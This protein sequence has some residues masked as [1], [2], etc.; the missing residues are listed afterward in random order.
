MTLYTSCHPFL[1]IMTKLVSTQQVQF[2]DS[3]STFQCTTCPLGKSSRLPF[4]FSSHTTPHALYLIHTNVWRPCPTSFVL[5]YRYYVLFLDDC[6]KFSWLYPMKSKAK[7]FGVFCTFKAR[8][9]KLLS[10]NIKVIR[11]DSSG[12]Y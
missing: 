3:V 9:E 10:H 6:T 4:S 5:G 7:M 11:S 1:H 8:I 12:E 2:S